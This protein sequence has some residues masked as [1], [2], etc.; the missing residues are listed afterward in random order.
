VYN[1]CKIVKWACVDIIINIIFFFTSSFVCYCVMFEGVEHCK[2]QRK[3]TRLVGHT[4]IRVELIYSEKGE[5]N[6]TSN[7][8]NKQEQHIQTTFPCTASWYR[9]FYANVGVS[10]IV[11]IKNKNIYKIPFWLLYFVRFRLAVIRKR[12]RYRVVQNQMKFNRNITIR[13]RH[14]RILQCELMVLTLYH[15]IVTS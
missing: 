9:E 1:G 13:S 11:I 7:Q 2:L 14:Y 6:R 4:K 12:D 3:F 8:L 5:F 10:L 15:I